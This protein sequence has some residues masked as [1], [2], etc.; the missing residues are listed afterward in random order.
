MIVGS[1]LLRHWSAAV[2]ASVA[3][4]PERCYSLRIT[5]RRVLGTKFPISHG[6]PA[7]NIIL[8][9]LVA[10]L[11]EYPNLKVYL[12]VLGLVAKANPHFCKYSSVPLH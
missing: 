5:W 3:A 1:E 4:G 7:K 10:A 11:S 12:H 6:T 8:A 2:A 9:M